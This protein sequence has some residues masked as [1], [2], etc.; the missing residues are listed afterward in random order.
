MEPKSKFKKGDRVVCTSWNAPYEGVGGTVMEVSWQ[1]HPSGVF[2]APMF[3]LLVILDTAEE[4]LEEAACFELEP[5]YQS[6]SYIPF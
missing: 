1:P 6:G 3:Y 5:D 4:V 2:S